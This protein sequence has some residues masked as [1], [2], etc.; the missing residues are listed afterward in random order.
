MRRVAVFVDPCN[1]VDFLLQLSRE[2]TV[3]SDDSEAKRVKRSTP[4][5]Y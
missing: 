3:M 4:S 5:K 2:K 1:V